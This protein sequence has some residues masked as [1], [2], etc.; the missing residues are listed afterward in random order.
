MKN[1]VMNIYKCYDCPHSSHTG[2]FTPGEVKR[3][4]DHPKTIKKK[5]RNCF[6]RIVDEYPE[7][8][9]WCPL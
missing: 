9:S 7:I 4:C 5:G 8:P 1:I 2:A 3:C 6:N